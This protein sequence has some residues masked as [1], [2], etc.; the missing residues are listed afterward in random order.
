MPPVGAPHGLTLVWA[1]D[2]HFPLATLTAAE[3]WARAVSLSGADMLVLTG[4]VSNCRRIYR[5]LDW[6]SRV[7]ARPACMETRFI[8]GNHDL[9]DAKHQET[10]PIENTRD[11][12]RYNLASRSGPDDLIY[13][14]DI[15]PTDRKCEIP[16][17]PGFV[18]LGVDGWWDGRAEYAKP[19]ASEVARLN[20]LKYARRAD[21]DTWKL[22]ER[23]N[24][25]LNAPGGPSCRGTAVTDIVILT[26]VPPYPEAALHNGK[27]TG[28]TMIGRYSNVGLGTMLSEIAAAN[29]KIL[30][31]VLCGHTHDD[32]YLR[33]APNLHVFVQ[34]AVHGAPSFQILRFDPLTRQPS[35]ARGGVAY[36]R[37]SA[38]F[39]SF[40]RVL[41]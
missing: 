38:P 17:Q 27:P 39:V 23:L 13:L 26:H 18:M 33:V 28:P 20:R 29:Q 25:I 16:H 30:F 5:D 41:G 32:A 15:E 8:L 2:I 14:H 7:A 4:D 6:I 36:E 11:A 35:I 3:L 9:L 40:P 34:G 10:C 24:R 12:L 19:P 37:D 31:T 22:R 21:L 1:S